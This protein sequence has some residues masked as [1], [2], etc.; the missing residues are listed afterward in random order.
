MLNNSRYKISNDEDINMEDSNCC[1]NI[2]ISDKNGQNVC[3]NCG[4][5]YNNTFTNVEKRAYSKEEMNNRKTTE[6]AWREFGPRTYLNLS[7]SIKDKNISNKKKANLKRLSKI[8]N[9]LISGVER[10]LWE[11]RPKL[12]MLC[13]KLNLPIHI[14]N[15]AWRIYK[16]VAKLK[17]TMGRTIDGFIGASLYAAI[18]INQF[19]KILAEVSESLM[20]P[21]RVIHKSLGFIIKDIFP[22]LNLKYNPI[23]P[24]ELIFKFGNDLNIPLKT[25]THALNLLKK[26][27][28]NG[29][30]MTGKDPRGVA[31]SVLYMVSKTDRLR[32]TQ[33]QISKAAHV[34][35]VTLRSG[36]KKIK[37]LIN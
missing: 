37:S 31:A 36:Q 35:E 16:E 21:R 19:P 5:V 4:V 26:A 12:K 3:L 17:L 9:S 29:F 8:Q 7:D 2:S 33:A 34:T 20:I 11:A 30:E 13:S 32:M 14:K 23:T 28:K 6:V 15:T 24:K 27:R 18:R 10:N 1:D 22:K 25:Q